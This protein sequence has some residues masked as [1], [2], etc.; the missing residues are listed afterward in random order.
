MKSARTELTSTNRPV[1]NADETA[2]R[3]DVLR[4]QIAQLGLGTLVVRRLGSTATDPPAQT[5]DPAVPLAAQTP[6][7]SEAKDPAEL[8]RLPGDRGQEH[9]RSPLGDGGEIVELRRT[10]RYREM[11]NRQLE[12]VDPA[13]AVRDDLTTNI[14]LPSPDEGGPTDADFWLPRSIYDAQQTVE[15]AAED[16]SY[17]AIVTG[18]TG[19]LL[20]GGTVASAGHEHDWIAT[21]L[22]MAALELSH[23]GVG[24]VGDGLSCKSIATADMGQGGDI[25][26]KWERGC[27]VEDLLCS[28]VEQ[29]S[30]PVVGEFGA[31]TDVPPTPRCLGWVDGGAVGNAGDMPDPACVMWIGAEAVSE[32]ACAFDVPI[33]CMMQM[34]DGSFTADSNCGKTEPGGAIAADGDCGK[35]ES[36]A[37]GAGIHSDAACGKATGY[38]T[39]KLEDADCALRAHGQGSDS[40]CG[41]SF[42]T[43][44][45]SGPDP[46]AVCGHVN[47]AAGYYSDAGCANV[48][49]GQ[50]DPDNH[51]GQAASRGDLA[52]QDRDCGRATGGGNSGPTTADSDC[53]VASGPSPF[54]SGDQSC[55]RQNNDGG[56]HGD[57]RCSIAR[58]SDEQP[59][60]T[61]PPRPRYD[62]VH[63]EDEINKICPEEG[64]GLPER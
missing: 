56:G 16:G 15:R 55:G 31:S 37:V 64:G 60:P 2:R 4:Y 24:I 52:S 62:P 10:Y 27:I 6:T 12:A 22:R 20:T 51:C 26:C 61:L 35:R 63:I 45:G 14:A 23:G 8:R 53:A 58:D 43:P 57:Q 1:G 17:P 59:G 25:M 30:C 48:A 29:P 34:P 32:A 5:A 11:V 19:A 18:G 49:G 54:E 13:V 28:L 41:G 21:S 38:G 7:T 50:L 46:D 44:T 3:D 33:P 39:T 40:N 36:T 47:D 9:T 42:A